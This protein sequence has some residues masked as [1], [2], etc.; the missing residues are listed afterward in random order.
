MKMQSL[1]LK[2][3]E[4]FQDSHSRALSQAWG[5]SKHLNGTGHVPLKLALL[6]GLWVKGLLTLCLEAYSR[7]K[8]EEEP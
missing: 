8:G 5:L 2:N 4:E 6:R 1:F 3:S 7:R